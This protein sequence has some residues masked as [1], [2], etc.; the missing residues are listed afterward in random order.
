[1]KKA[2]A[3]TVIAMSF[4]SQVNAQT[5]FASNTV[6]KP[7]IINGIPVI[8]LGNEGLDN[9]NTVLAANPKLKLKFSSLFP[10]AT[11]AHWVAVEKGFYVTYMNNGRKSSASF[12]DKGVL[13]YSLSD[14]RIDQL[15]GAFR[16]TIEKEYAGYK[17]VN[18][19]EIFAQDEVSFQAVL[20]N[21]T[22]FVT[23]RCYNDEVEKIKQV[24]K[25]N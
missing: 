13:N 7:E 17:L 23:L 12:N 16:K 25:T 18:G 4:L 9:T 2:L 24:L 1:M 21:A 8:A 3:L 11:S 6:P 5:M 14:C 20:E 22:G 10:G 19:L 15:P